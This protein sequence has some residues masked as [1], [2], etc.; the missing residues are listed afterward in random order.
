L[1]KIKEQLTAQY[2]QSK[3][4]IVPEIDM[5][6]SNGKNIIKFKVVDNDLF[7]T[8]LHDGKL[9]YQKITDYR[10]LKGEIEQYLTHLNNLETPVSIIKEH[11]EHLYKKLFTDDFNTSAPTVIIPDDILHYLPFDLLV[12]DNAYL[13]ENHTISYA[14]N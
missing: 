2:R 12:K 1:K 10:V 5:T 4:F 9:T 6:V 3:L 13:V 8:R 14:P 11:G 7:K